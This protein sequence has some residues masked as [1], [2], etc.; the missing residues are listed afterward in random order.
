MVEKHYVL[1][2]KSSCPHCK[3]ALATLRDKNL[4]F[5]YT[6]ME[7]ATQVLEETKRQSDWQ[8]VPMIWEQTVDWSN[9]AQQVLSNEFIGGYSELDE[10]LNAATLDEQNRLDDD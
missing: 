5:V 3:N 8:T 6:D 1:V 10:R 7:Y 4:S 2:V 9:P